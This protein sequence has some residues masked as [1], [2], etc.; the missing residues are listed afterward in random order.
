M[1]IDMNTLQLFKSP[2]VVLLLVPVKQIKQHNLN[3]EKWKM[4]MRSNHMKSANE[5]YTPYKNTISK[6]KCAYCSQYL[7]KSWNLNI[8][9]WTKKWFF[10]SQSRAFNLFLGLGQWTYIRRT[11]KST[12]YLKTRYTFESIKIKRST[13]LFLYSLL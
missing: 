1:Y 8:G 10:F 7:T 6:S 2:N 9:Q 5:T 13:P 3:I 11:L 12:Y 4:K